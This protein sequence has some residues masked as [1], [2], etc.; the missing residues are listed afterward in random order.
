MVRRWRR[1][2]K[3]SVAVRRVCALQRR[4]RLVPQ[5]A[6]ERQRRQGI[7]RGGGVGLD[8]PRS[9]LLDAS[10][11]LEAVG[12]AAARMCQLAR[13]QCWRPSQ[14]LHIRSQLGGL[15][16]SRCGQLART[17]SF[18]QLP[19]R[20]ALGP[21]DLHRS[22]KVI[23]TEGQLLRGAALVGDGQLAMR[24][25]SFSQLHERAAINLVGLL[26]MSIASMASAAIGQLSQGTAQGS[27]GQLARG[28]QSLAS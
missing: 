7:V 18:G 4:H 20:A 11:A 13:A 24:P 23:A 26:G 15:V 8:P 3:T 5:S 10:H 1:T 14:L 21:G 17:A 2:S 28:R 12:A 27:V 9:P 22:H 19:V 25:A 6:R 16:R